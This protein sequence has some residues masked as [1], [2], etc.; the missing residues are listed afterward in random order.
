MMK[1]KIALSTLITFITLITLTTIV[2]PA[3]ALECPP[4]L[5][6]CNNPPG[7]GSG[8]DIG[9]IDTGALPKINTGGENTFVAGVVR[10]GLQLLLIIAF[11]IDLIWT[12]LAGFQFIFAGGDP[13]NISTAWSRIYWGLIGMVIVFAS[14]AIIRIVEIFFDINLISGGLTLPRI[15]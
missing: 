6:T 9:K 14:F 15:N 13:K 8:V 2:S 1:I 10:N 7:G 3:F 12:I 4:E 11:I 5:P